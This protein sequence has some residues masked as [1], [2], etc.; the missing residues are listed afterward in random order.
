MESTN[1]DNL[2]PEKLLSAWQTDPAT[3]RKWLIEQGISADTGR[4]YGSQVQQ[5]IAFLAHLNYATVN[6]LRDAGDFERSVKEYRD[7]LKYAIKAG[8]SAINNNLM[9]ID[10]FCRFL[11]IQ[12]ARLEREQR[13]RKSPRTL[14]PNQQE[15]FL[16][17]VKQ[18]ALAR[19]R[20]LALVL[21]CTGIRIGEC[22]ALNISDVLI[23]NNNAYLL[24]P[25]REFVKEADSG[26]IRSIDRRP[27]N[28]DTTKALQHWLTDRSQFASDTTDQA[29]WITQQGKRL[30]V[31]GI[32]YTI[33]R[34]GWKAHLMLSAEI[35]RQTC[36]A[37]LV[38]NSS[39]ETLAQE[40]GP[41]INFGT[42]K[43]YSLPGSREYQK[44]VQDLGA[45]SQ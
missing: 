35:L 7:F 9:A 18:Q 43:Q 13:G 21:L 29:L 31:A 37:N 34:I 16:Q 5:F 32:D 20:A 41:Y 33:R 17:S 11:G 39:K 23:E 14:T 10:H 38:K 30:S 2:S 24:V 22:A 12:P 1:R 3:Y 4:V 19:D 42:V 26:D 27:L 6:C 44:I 15:L 45:Y 40:L 25:D 36:I 8:P 28:S